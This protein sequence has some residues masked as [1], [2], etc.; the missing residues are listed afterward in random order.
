MHRLSCIISRLSPLIATILLLASASLAHAEFTTEGVIK[1]LMKPYTGPYAEQSVNTKT[2]TNK[3]MCGYQ[4]WFTAKGDGSE[5]DWFHWEWKGGFEPGKCSIDLWPDVTELDADELYDTAFRKAD[6]SVAP[7]F[8]SMNEKTVVRHF[9][10]MQDYGIDGVFVQRFVGE[11]FNPVSLNHSTTVLSHCRTGANTYGR[12]YALMYDLSGLQAGQMDMVIEDFKRLV[13]NMKLTR[14]PADRAYLH[15]RGKP[16]VSVWGVGFNDNRPYTL[17][18][19]AKLVDFLKNDP[20]YGGC[21]VMVGIP[22]YW[23]TLDRDSVQDARLHD[24]IKM[25]DIVSP[26][27]P[28]RYNSPESVAEFAKDRWEP[29]VRWCETNGKDYLPV[30]FPGFSWHNMFEKSPFDAIPRLRGRFLWKQYIE[31]RK[32]GVTMIYQA[33]FDEVDEGT[34]IFKCTNNP[35]VGKSEF[36]TYE[37]LPSDYYLRMVGEG[38]R[39][40]R[41]EIPLKDSDLPDALAPLDKAAREAEAAQAQEK[42][43]A[44]TKVEGDK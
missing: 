40:L 4:G 13:D 39:L 24:V 12:T 25:A 16:V 10:W 6:G 32:A 2:L 11:T 17:D 26:W 20:D 3:V 30:M 28:G 9:K 29:D 33:M 21:T 18:D 23:R 19:C 15:H 8:S 44:E 41:C 36:L 27:T 35:P 22:S 43:Q 1:R 14:D 7:V 37:G 5:R 31:A 34:A 42:A 38:G